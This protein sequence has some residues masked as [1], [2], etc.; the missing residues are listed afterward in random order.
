[1]DIVPTD[2]TASNPPK[3]QFLG[4]LIRFAII[5]ILIVFPIRLFVA[6]PFIVSGASM[7]P[8]FEN[9]QYLIIDEITYRLDDPQRRKHPEQDED[10]TPR[11][12]ENARTLLP[13][14]S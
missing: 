3:E 5:A 11:D 14:S 7:E 13:P 12:V 4:E 6:Q 1:M 2:T 8:T 9:G 10:F